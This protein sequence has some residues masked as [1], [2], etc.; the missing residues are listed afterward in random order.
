MAIS[1]TMARSTVKSTKSR[2]C[3]AFSKRKDESAVE[4]RAHEIERRHL[5][6]GVTSQAG[7]DDTPNVG[8]KNLARLPG[9]R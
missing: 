3:S 5:D 7:L 6:A 1:G 2:C 4:L 8:H 9:G